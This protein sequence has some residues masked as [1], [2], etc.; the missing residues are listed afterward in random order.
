MY[1]HTFFFCVKNLDNIAIMIR[2]LIYVDL[3]D[4]YNDV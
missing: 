4:Y 3:K 2:M 1:I